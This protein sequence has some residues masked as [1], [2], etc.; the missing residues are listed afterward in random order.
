MDQ[1]VARPDL[2]GEVRFRV[3]LVL[4]IPISA[5]LVIGLLAFGF[6]RILLGLESKEGA[7]ALAIVM[8]ANVLA[9]SAYFALRP[10]LQRASVI[11][12]LVVALY[13]VVIGIALAQTGILAEGEHATETSTETSQE[14]GAPAPSAG[15]EL[16][17]QNVEWDTATLTVQAGEPIEI[18]VE[19]QDST[20]HNLSIYED[21]AAAESQSDPLFQGEDVAAGASTTYEIDPLKKGTYT[22]I[23]DYHI[24]MIGDLEVE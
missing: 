21:E 5:I 17:A 18:P 8:A 16:V 1:E 3:P 13:P 4:A 20:V 22:F 10:R 11:E 9:A 2:T 15:T 12:L 6:S 14:K 7:T 24:N 23:C 19:N